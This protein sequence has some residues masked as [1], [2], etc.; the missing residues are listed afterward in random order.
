[1]MWRKHANPSTVPIAEHNLKDGGADDLRVPWNIAAHTANRLP[2]HCFT[3]L[4]RCD[5]KPPQ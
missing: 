1:M 2:H 3:P 5:Q 4:S